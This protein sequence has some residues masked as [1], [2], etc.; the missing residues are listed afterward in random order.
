[1]DKRGLKVAH[2]YSDFIESEVKFVYY[3][4]KILVLKD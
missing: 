2:N 4:E 3:Q 1:M